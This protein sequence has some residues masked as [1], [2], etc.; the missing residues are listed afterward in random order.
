MVPWLQDGWPEGYSISVFAS[1]LCTAL[2]G[3]LGALA[4]PEP[5]HPVPAQQIE[6][7]YTVQQYYTENKGKS[8]FPLCL[9][10]PADEACML[11]LRAADAP[12]PAQCGRELVFT[13]KWR[14]SQKRFTA[15]APQTICQLTHLIK[16]HFSIGSDQAIVLKE[17]HR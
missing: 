2:D 14:N 7:Y 3:S 15:Y 8:G 5:V 4:T 16:D 9:Q 6:E 12:T 17:V 10:R 11:F 13:C 1:E